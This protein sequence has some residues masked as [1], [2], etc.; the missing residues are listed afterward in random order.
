M[1]NCMIS[2]LY[3]QALTGHK[4][5]DNGVT[6]SQVSKV[7]ESVNN[8]CGVVVSEKNVRGR[9]KTIKKEYVELRQLLSMSGFGLEPNTGRVTADALA[10][11]EF[12]KG[13]PEFGKW[14]N[15]LCP[16]YDELEVILGNDVATGERSI[17]GNDDI[18]PIHVVDESVNEIDSQS[19][20]TNSSKRNDSKRSAEGGSN[21]SRRRR[22][23]PDDNPKE[24]ETIRPLDMH[25]GME[26]RFGLSKG[27]AHPSFI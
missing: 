5:S 17:A 2:A 22:T 11:E 8:V 10:W 4:R 26:V 27:P 24:S 1:D 18:S 7:I 19:E 23:Q 15:K 14:K 6:S 3:H 20:A 12:L 16:R 21:R 25:H 13:K 9:L